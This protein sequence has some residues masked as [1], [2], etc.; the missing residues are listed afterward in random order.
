[1]PRSMTGFGEAQ[2][3]KD[4]RRY[5]VEVRAVNGRFLKCV[6]RVSDDLHG[7]ESD[8]EK[9]VG[10]ILRRGSVT[11]SV[12]CIEESAGAAATI[13]LAALEQYIV[14]VQPLATKF[15]HHID[16]ASLLSLPGVVSTESDGSGV[17]SAKPF[18][19]E[20]VAE[21]IGQVDTMR[22]HE[23]AALAADI[24]SHLD[25]IQSHVDHIQ[26]LA[27]RVIEA[28]QQRLRQ[29]M[30]SL[31]AEVEAEFR[32]EDLLREVAVFAERTDIAEELSRLSAHLVQFRELLTNDNELIG[33]T[34]DFLCQ[35]ML[36]EANTIGSKCLD[37]DVAR[38]VVEVK[39]AVD[40]VKEQ[41]Q[42]LE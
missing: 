12:R 41:V 29:R 26:G 8:I 25:K 18:I 27:P 35:E 7:I 23:G 6:P 4:G 31:L 38:Y 30:E 11:V 40:R 34:L 42:N 33:R 19:L 14:Q 22:R 21:A 5:S 1:M 15:S 2:S 10:S 24:S 13:N 39:G 32:Q 20:L 37:S 17:E 9:V 3:V 28:Y 16:I 36:R